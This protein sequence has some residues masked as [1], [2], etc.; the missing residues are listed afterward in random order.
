M[1]SHVTV[2]KSDKLYVD[3]RSY[4]IR[5]ELAEDTASYIK[6]RDLNIKKRRSVFVWSRDKQTVAPPNGARHGLFISDVLNV[7]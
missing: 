1:L 6:V 3:R 2:A 4:G 7:K 5:L